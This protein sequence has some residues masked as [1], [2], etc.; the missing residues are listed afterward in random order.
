MEHNLLNHFLVVEHLKVTS[1]I[2]ATINNSV[3]EP[4]CTF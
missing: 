2:F 1:N 4:I 3:K